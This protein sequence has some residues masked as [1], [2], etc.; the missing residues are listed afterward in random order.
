M[1]RKACRISGTLFCVNAP[2]APVSGRRK[3]A[4]LLSEKPEREKSD[5][6]QLFHQTAGFIHEKEKTVKLS[7]DE[8]LAQYGDMVYRIAMSHTNNQRE[9]ADDIFQNVFIKYMTK[10]P[11]FESEEHCKAWLIRVTINESCKLFQSTWSQRVTKTDDLSMYGGDEKFWEKEDDG[12]FQAMQQLPALYRD[13][14]HLFYYEELSIEQIARAVGKKEGTVKS[15]LHRGRNQLRE[16]L[17]NSD[18]GKEGVY[19]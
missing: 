15:L 7:A 5:L 12:V 17:L 8:A 3:A 2:G 16:L 4:A 14:L 11:D 9:D 18:E 10:A 19:R 6:M 13:V 1:H